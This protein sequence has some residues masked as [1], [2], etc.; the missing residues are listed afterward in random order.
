MTRALDSMPRAHNPETLVCESVKC[1]SNTEPACDLESRVTRSP[2]MR[3]RSLLLGVETKPVPVSSR[4]D[5]A[6]LIWRIGVASRAC[7][8]GLLCGK[9][10][11][12][13][14]R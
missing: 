1:L 5:T 6:V 11:C 8:R 3:A 14:V 12:R 9:V 10:P 2:W 7:Y 13:S 4:E